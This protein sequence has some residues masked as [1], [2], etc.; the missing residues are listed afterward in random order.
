MVVSLLTSSPPLLPP[1]PLLCTASPCPPPPTAMFWFP[2]PTPKNLLVFAPSPHIAPHS[3]LEGRHR[4]PQ[5]PLWNH[6]GPRL[7]ASHQIFLPP[8]LPATVTPSHTRT[9][10]PK[11]LIDTAPPPACRGGRRGVTTILHLRHRHLHP[12]ACPVCVCAVHSPPTTLPPPPP[13]PEKT[14]L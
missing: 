2:P 14:V 12:H 8:I 5:C 1:L 9:G 7:L 4:G 3:G 10:V 13:P 11:H 6:R